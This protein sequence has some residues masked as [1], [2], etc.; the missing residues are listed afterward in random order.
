MSEDVP[1]VLYLHMYVC[2]CFRVCMH[3]SAHV[4][5]LSRHCF[6]EHRKALGVGGVGEWYVI[7]QYLPYAC[8]ID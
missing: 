6:R 1:V 7:Y 8:G 4:Y 3:R 5:T 2:V